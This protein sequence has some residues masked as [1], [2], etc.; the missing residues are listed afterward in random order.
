[1]KML[2]GCSSEVNVC[3]LFYSYQITPCLRIRME[4]RV[5]LRMEM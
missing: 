2:L 1:M 5:R 3:L 4:R